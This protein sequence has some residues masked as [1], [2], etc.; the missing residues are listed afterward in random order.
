MRRAGVFALAGAVIV[1]SG[2]PALAQQP[3]GVTVSFSGEM[4]VLGVVSDNM[5]DFADTGKTGPLARFG[6]TPNKDSES[7]YFQRWRLYTT[8]ESADKK[9]KAVWGLEVGDLFWG[10]LGGSNGTEFGGTT[11]RVGN[12]TGAEL[13]ADGVNVETKNAYIQFAVPGIPN[14]TLLFGIHNLRFMDTPA[15][16][17]MDDDG[18]GIQFNWKL[19][20]ID[21]QL[22]T[23]KANENNVQDADDNDF[24]A[25][26]LGVNLTPDTR[27]TVEG[28]I[29]NEQCFAR[30]APVPPAATGSCVS[31]D[32]GDTF[33]VGGTFA[34]KVGAVNLD[35]AVIHGQRALYSASLDRTIE[36]RGSGVQ[37]VA[38]VPIGLLRTWWFGRYSTGDKNRITGGGCPAL[39]T[40]HP[41]CGRLPAGTEFSTRSFTTNLTRNSDK[42]PIPDFG[43]SWFTVPFVGE[44]LFGLPTLGAPGFGGSTH[45]GDSTGTWTVGGSALLPLATTFSVGG[46]VA[47]VA[48]SEG[49]GVYGDHAIE[50]DA[51][52]L[53]TYNANLSFQAIAGYVI[54]DAG[55]NAWGMSFRTRFAF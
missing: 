27:L 25:A 28:M 47:Y 49:T 37:L 6:A 11:T 8:V 48:A 46:G 55:D 50:I 45:Y 15:G 39:P 24:Y 3:P 16:A 22:W 19:D 33:W 2:L 23:A 13:G 18:A 51:G 12:S 43:A 38:R 14:A 41:L 10:R 1:A 17:F 5:S 53:Y 42:L 20:P 26:R 9:A 7:Y 44:Y 40:P 30:R 32:F 4:R 29:I 36:E 21:L 52:A 54:P 35:G 34:T 31:A